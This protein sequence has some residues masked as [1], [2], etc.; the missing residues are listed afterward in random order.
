MEGNPGTDEDGRD[1][2][3][4]DAGFGS[5]I[6][7]IIA[8][9]HQNAGYDNRRIWDICEGIGCQPVERFGNETYVLTW[10]KGLE[11]GLLVE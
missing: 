8:F 10:K 2:A 11:G 1:T 6:I 7:D 4:G 3:C 9:G 5:V